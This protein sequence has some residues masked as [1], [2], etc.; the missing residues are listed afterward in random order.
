MSLLE[1]HYAVGHIPDL[2]RNPVIEHPISN[3][4]LER[5]QVQPDGV[6]L[7]K[8]EP[9][10]SPLPVIPAP[11]FVIPDVIRNPMWSVDRI[12]EEPATMSY[13]SPPHLIFFNE[14]FLRI[15]SVIRCHLSINGSTSLY[16]F[17]LPFPQ[18]RGILMGNS[19]KK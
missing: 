8:P 9:G 6:R 13:Q 19:T 4:P 14:V 1:H 15:L 12:L 18:A 10:V 11:L 2:I 17:G 5:W 16:Y 3:S 7:A